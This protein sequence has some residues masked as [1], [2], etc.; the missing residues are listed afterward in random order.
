MTTNYYNERARKIQATRDNTQGGKDIIYNLYNFKGELISTYL[1]HTNPKSTATPQ[2]TLLT[3]Y[4][5]DR[6]GRIDTVRKQVNDDPVYSKVLSISTYNEL[7][8][9]IQKRLGVSGS[10]QLETQNYEY[11]VRGWL[12]GINKSFV[13]SASSTSNWFGQEICYDYGF[14]G[15]QLNGNMAGQ[16]WKGRGDRVSRSYGYNYDNLNRLLFANFNQQ[17][18]GASIWTKDKVDF[19]TS[20]LSYDAMGNLLSMKQ[21]GMNGVVI[22]P[23]DSL[24]YG[25][26]SNGNKLRFVT[27]KYNN[28]QSKLG[29]FKEIVG[30]T[31]QDYYYNGSGSLSKDNNKNIDTILY[32]H[33]NK[34]STVWVKNKGKIFFQYRGGD[35]KISKLISDTSNGGKY[36]WIHYI[37]DFVYEAGADGVDT[38]KSIET[39]EGRI[40]PIYKAGSAVSY[41]FDYYVKDNQGNIRVVLGTKSDTAV[42]AATMETN[43]S[44]VENALFSNIDNT[45][46]A[47]PS[48]YPTDN[49]TNPNDY[50]S[51]LNANSNKIGPSIVL[52]VM[53][54][55]TISIACKALYKDN[56]ASTSASTSSAMV[57]S[58]LS[59][60]SGGGIVDGVHYGTGVTAPISILTPGIYDNLKSKDP[61]ENLSDKPKA[62]LNFA[63]FDD[64]FNLVDEN[65]GVRQVKGL[66][67]S[68]NSL[69]VGKTAISKTGFIYIYLSNES[70]Q[71]VL[72]DNLIVSHISGPL[73]EETHYYPHGGSLVGIGAKALKS[74]LYYGNKRRYNGK[75]LQFNEMK[76]GSGTEWYDFGSRMYEYQIGRWNVQDPK[77]EKFYNYSPYVYN[78]NNPNNNLD[79]NGQ[80]AYTLTG[81]AARAAFKMFQQVYNSA[82]Y[83]RFIIHYVYQSE[84]PG[85]YENTINAFKAGKSPWLTYDP[86]KTNKKDRRDIAL[87]DY[88]RKAF[89]PEGYSWDEYPFA[90]TMEGGKGSIVKA[91]PI[92]EQQRQGSD[93]GTAILMAHLKK[94]EHILVIP[95]ADSQST[96]AVPQADISGWMA[97]HVIESILSK[98]SPTIVLP[99]VMPE[100][101]WPQS[102]VLQ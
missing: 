57:S 16:K 66:K 84:T 101:N 38:L 87:Y 19:T 17:N 59:A 82:K 81:P 54:G 35:E 11:N 58:I 83:G 5:R 51:K 24:R 1:K 63:L 48:Y 47:K 12:R 42:Y 94:G 31:T 56:S 34:V 77:I 79:P 44:S 88:K 8:Q 26:L 40:R 95:V 90:C 32:N 68:L 43:A 39:E 4:H 52:R 20:S 91:V 45:R 60:F 14:D 80:E 86:S 9:I 71:D 72:F 65:S 18:P 67:D 61:T 28:P 100:G 6:I 3:M 96:E 10:T 21:M 13:N 41:T 75:E 64:Q 49:T 2:V 23:V 97:I 30:D 93:L 102:P 74:N 55:D 69:V 46:F 92:A 53:A 50:V 62:Y 33:N 89:M 22:Q 73:L 98:F 25:Y 70:A 36:Q 29:D 78:Y 27:D 7:E 99:P 15:V 85:I 76:D 37:G